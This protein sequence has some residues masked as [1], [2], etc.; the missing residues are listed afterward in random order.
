MLS[1]T[2]QMTVTVFLSLSLQL[3]RLIRYFLQM[4]NYGIQ[5]RRNLFYWNE[6]GMIYS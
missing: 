6:D 3:L 4:I 5:K 1:R 2:M